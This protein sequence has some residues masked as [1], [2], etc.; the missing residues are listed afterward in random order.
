MRCAE[1]LHGLHVLEV[2]AIEKYMLLRGE[3]L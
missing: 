3:Q 2:F 1:S